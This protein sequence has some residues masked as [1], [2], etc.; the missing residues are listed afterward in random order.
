MLDF[1]LDISPTTAPVLAALEKVLTD[2]AGLYEV[3]ALDLEEF[4]R[5]FVTRAAADRHSTARRLGARPTGYLENAAQTFEAKATVGGVQ[6]QVAGAIFKRTEGPVVIRGREK[7]LLTIPAI[8]GAYGRRAGEIEGLR[9]VLFKKSGVKALVR[10]RGKGKDRTM[11]VW[12]WLKEE[13]TLPQ[14]PGLLP[15]PE[16]YALAAEPGAAFYLE[17]RIAEVLG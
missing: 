10:N 4:G 12:F 15:T 1:E 5:E 7:Q 2:P 3:I 6:L 8:A 9:F 11:E 17:K 13:V 16:Q 14:D